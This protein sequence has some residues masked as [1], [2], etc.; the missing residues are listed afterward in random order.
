M[1]ANE[2]RAN[3]FRQLNEAEDAA[4]RRDARQ[5]PIPKP[6]RPIRVGDLVEFPVSASRRKWCLW[7]RTARCSSSRRAQ[8]QGQ[9]R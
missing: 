8:T 9:G 3:L 5:E 2:A 4:T 1:N 6:S 7:A